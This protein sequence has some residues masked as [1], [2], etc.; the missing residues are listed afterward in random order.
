MNIEISAKE[1]RDLLDI[2]HI[3]DAVMS[4]HRREEDKRTVRHRVLIQTL[5]A[6][7][8]SEGLDRLI[9]YNESVKKY[10][11]TAEFE[12][13][14]LAH[15]VIHEF[16][17]H[18][19]WDEL[20]NRLTIRDAAQMA[21]GKERLNTLSARERQQMDGPI[22]QRYVQEFATNGVSRLEIFERFSGDDGVPAMTSD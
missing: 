18:L 9:S 22:R 20:V 15:V 6:L 17:D 14:T 10:V 4:G 13:N 5:Y 16:G 12:E 11:P 7:A 1:Y 8:R 19:F 21:G 2:L 3:A